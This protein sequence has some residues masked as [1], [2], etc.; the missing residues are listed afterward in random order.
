MKTAKKILALSAFLVTALPGL[1][2]EAAKDALFLCSIEFPQTIKS[3]PNLR[4]YHLGETSGKIV[5]TVIEGNKLDLTIYDDESREQIGILFTEQLEEP[6]ENNQTH[7]SV[8]EK[9]PF[10][11]YLMTKKNNAQEGENKWN[12]KEYVGVGR[13]SKIIENTIVVLLD[14][15]LV[16][17]LKQVNW[18]QNTG[19]VKLPNV[20]ISESV[21]QETQML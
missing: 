20:K 21:S 5:D 10:K 14:P 7:L 2:K 15:S 19:V 1:A 12:Y 6:K 8:D 11:F 17:G 18:K 16:E 3:V 4:A 9:A 13:P